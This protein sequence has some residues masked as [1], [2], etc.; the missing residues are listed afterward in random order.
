M[1]V[2]SNFE[3]DFRVLLINHPTP[4]PQRIRSAWPFSRSRPPLDTGETDKCRCADEVWSES[5][6]RDERKHCETEKTRER[7]HERRQHNT[8]YN[9]PTQR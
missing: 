6:R 1:T 2:H 4:D 9:M 3:R 5:T 8:A 7:K